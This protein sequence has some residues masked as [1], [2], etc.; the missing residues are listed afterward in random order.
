MKKYKNIFKFLASLAIIAIV[1]FA[2]SAVASFVAGHEVNITLEV[3]TALLVLGFLKGLAGVRLAAGKYAFDDGFVISDTSYAGEVAS[4]FLVK[5][6]TGSDTVN[7][8]HVYIKDGIK[9]KFTIPRFDVDYEDLIQDRQATPQSKG[10]FDIDGKVLD[11]QDFMIY[12]EFNPRDFEDHW[13]AT[14]LNPTLLDRALPATPESVVIQ[15]V[16]KR[17][18]KYF[19]KLI[20]NGDTTTSGIYKYFNGFIANALADATVTDVSSPVTLTVNNIQGEF[21]RGYN[22]IPEALRYDPSMKIFCS[23]ATYDL[24]D[25]SQ[26]NQT[27]KGVDITQLGKD[28]FKGKKVVKIAD[29]PDNCFMIAKG[30]ASTESNL[31]VGMNSI[32]DEGLQLARLQANSELFFIKMLVKA[33][34]QIGWGN[35]VVLYKA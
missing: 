19:N 33:D 10:S 17:Y 35:E 12:T 5:A 14:Q 15:E 29:F 18:M 30:T 24:Y 27:Y 6:I 21:L 31:W 4:Q 28:T 34:V 8:G 11:P 26:V 25:Q 20:W 13:Y 16:M 23:Y 7:G 22:A 9:K 32:Q 2:T 1:S 3:A